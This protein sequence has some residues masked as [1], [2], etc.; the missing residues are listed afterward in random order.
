LNGSRNVRWALTVAALTLWAFVVVFAYFVVH[1]PFDAG[2]VAALLSALVDVATA[3]GII[4]VAIGLGARLIPSVEDVSPL[5]RAVLGAGIGLGFVGLWVL[6]VGLLGGLYRPAFWAMWLAGVALCGRSAVRLLKAVWADGLALPSTRLHR[7]LAFFV[8]V[9]LALVAIEALLPP[10]AWDSLVYHLTGPKLHIAAHRIAPGIDLPYLGFPAQVEMLFTAGLL[11]KGPVVAALIHWSFAALTVLLL[12]VVA[13]RYFDLRVAWWAMALWT[14]VPTIMWLASW[15]YIDVGL[16]FFC[17]AA[18]YVGLRWRDTGERRWLLLSG[19]FAGLAMGTKYTAVGPALALALWIVWSNRTV[20][21]RQRMVDLA[22]WAG[23]ALAVLGPW[24]GKN[25]AFTGNPVYPFIF[26]GVYWDAF[27]RYWYS[28]GGTGLAYSAP[29]Q[30]LTAPWDM[31]IT[32]TEGKDGFSAT[33]G[34]LLLIGLPVLV[35]GWHA[36]TDGER[37]LLRVLGF[38]VLVQYAIWLVG[39]GSSALLVQSRLLFPAFPLLALMLAFALDRMRHL[40]RSAFAVDWVL[41]IVAVLFLTL[42]LLGAGLEVIA[43]HPLAVITGVE[44][45]ESYL[46][47]HLGS[48]YEAIEYVNHS[49]PDYSRVLFWWEPRSYYCDR[50]CRP[51]ALLDGFKHLTVRF[52]DAVSI[53]AYLRVQGITHVLLCQQ[54]LGAILADRFDPITDS[55]MAILH[56]LQRD[57]LQ[58]VYGSERE[59]YV[60]YQVKTP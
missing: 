42:D 8:G 53:A 27:R 39:V 45:R 1:K 17:L 57:F 56:D 32:G 25:W 49:L 19:V 48:Y 35:V 60:V 43:D 5:E 30:L 36:A 29:W 2:R 37:R 50:D 10:T 31:T 33:I 54:G 59:P 4:F 16:M 12:Y 24:L 6:A 38:V 52:G 13:L 46:A 22:A 41:G 15:P 58:P 44:S 26:D 21:F 11:L 9:R 14:G 18:L 34:P 55:D 47:R 7:F 3:A 28:R 51:D 23:T 40:R 20:G